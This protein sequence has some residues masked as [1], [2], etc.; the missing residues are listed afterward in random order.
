MFSR[1]NRLAKEVY[2][3]TPAEAREKAICLCC[4]QS[5]FV[6]AADGTSK[7]NP[8]MF[9]SEAGKKEWDISCMCE[10]CFDNMFGEEEQ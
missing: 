7:Y 6:L 5:V 10:K 3:M 8:E 9:Y 4:K 2:G 1:T